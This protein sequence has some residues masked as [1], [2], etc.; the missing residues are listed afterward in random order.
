VIVT[1][2]TTS[3]PTEAEQRAREQ[4]LTDEVVASFAGSEAKRYRALMT[5]LVRHL[6]GFARD[7]RL[8][9]AEET[10]VDFLTRTGHICDDR[11]QEFIL[12]S[13]VLGLSMLTVGINA[14]DSQGATESTVFGPFFVDDAPQVPLGGDLAQGAKGVPCY[15]SGQVRCT[16]GTPL[17]GRA[18]TPGRP[19]R[20][21][22]TT[23]STR[24]TA[25]PGAA[26]RPLGHT[27]S[28]GSGRCSPSTTPSRTTAR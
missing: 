15:V 18:S 11:R 19:M 3:A 12:L 25:P 6:H 2:S 5:S 21:A 22:A 10:A 9:Q 7:V 14:A 20:T 24:A 16:G 23:P 26:G 8:T 1:E 13:D 27:A 17:A 4:A 28:T